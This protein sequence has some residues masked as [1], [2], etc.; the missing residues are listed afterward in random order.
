MS[1]LAAYIMRGR[2]QAM[3]VASSLALLS[4]LLPP[5]SIVSSGAVALVTLRRGAYEGLIVLLCS[6]VVAAILG[7]LLLGSYHFPLLYGLLLWFPIW[8]IAVVLREARHLSLTVELTVMLGVMGVLGFYVWVSNPS[9]MW[10]G[11]LEQM[12]QPLLQTP[13]VPIEKVQQSLQAFSRF[14][15]GIVAA[16]SVYSL[17]FGLFLARWWQSALY[18]PGGFR[19]EFLSL[20]T[21]PRLAI[22]SIVVVSVA[23]WASGTVAEI[24]QNMSVLFFVLYTFIGVAV[25][26]SLFANMKARRYLVPTLYFVLM[27][28]PHTMIPVAVV[29]LADAWL[30]LRNKHSNQ[31]VA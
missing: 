20:K 27:A 15:T 25:L 10:L 1:F 12:T 9:Q 17:L 7:G 13:D 26:H 14:M 23:M 2:M 6:C 3:L 16:G 29:G 4:L 28:I 21:Q 18:N 8:L 19:Q 24:A 30:N 11:L 5:I 22:F 31:N